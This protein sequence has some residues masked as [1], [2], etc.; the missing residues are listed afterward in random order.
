MTLAPPRPKL[1]LPCAVLLCAALAGSA[2]DR[3]PAPRAVATKQPAVT[4]VGPASD[5]CQAKL[6]AL[7]HMMEDQPLVADEVAYA[8]YLIKD[9]TEDAGPL[10]DALSVALAGRAPPVV[11]S[12]GDQFY[13]R[14]GRTMDQASGRPVKVFQARVV[15][16]RGAPDNP[17]PAAEVRASWQSGRL[18][19]GTYR[20]RLRKNGG[21]WQVV[22]RTV[23]EP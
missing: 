14:R 16:L 6:A 13:R 12:E 17:A 18:A 4:A 21:A 1:T 10:A 8:A 3:R 11:A 20:Y 22:E 7:R 15:D 5:A 9:T 19:G 2:C 23:E